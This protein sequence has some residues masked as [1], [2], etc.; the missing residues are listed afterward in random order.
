VR[1]RLVLAVCAPL[2]VGAAPAPGGWSVSASDDVGVRLESKTDDPN[3]L[4]FAFDFHGTAGYASARHDLPM[5]LPADYRIRFRLRGTGAANTLQLKFLDASGQNVWWWRRVDQPLPT[6]WTEVS[7]EP[8]QVEFAWGPTKDRRLGAIASVEATVA[9]EQGGA[10]AVEIRDLRIEP[11]AP[12][13]AQAPALATA[14]APDRTAMVEAAAKAAPRGRYPR[15]FVGEQP[16]WTLIGVEGGADS[17]LMSE[18]G[19]L[20]VGRGGFSIEPFVVQDG[21]LVSWADVA[22]RQSLQ[23]G[24]LPMP[25]VRWRAK[26][27]TLDVRGFVAGDARSARLYGRY[28]IANTTSRPLRL[29]LVLAVRP[30][31]VNGPRQFLTTPGGASKIGRA[32]WDGSVL[33]VDQRGVRPLARPDAVGVASFDDGGLDAALAQ[34]RRR[35]ITA[36]DAK[37][38]ATAALVYDLRLAPRQRRVIGVETPLIGAPSTAAPA[39]LERERQLTAAHWRAALGRVEISAGGEG[40]EVTAAIRTSLAH[41]LISREGPALRPG[42]RSYARSWIRDGSMMAE[43]LLRLD[44]AD[45]ARDYLD[46]YGPHQ[47]SSGKI[48]CCVDHRGADPTPE[49]DSQGEYLFLAGEVWR[50]T[51]DR[52]TAEA[53]WPYVLAAARD[54]DR[55]RLSER[56]EANRTPER[57]A[58]WGLMPPSISHEGYSD[59]PAYSYWDDLWAL[60]G[61]RAGVDLAQ[62]L[63][64]PELAELTA[65]RDQFSADLKA[66]VEAAG[67]RW[68]I[69]YMPGAADRGDFDATSTT[70]ALAPGDPGRGLSQPRL[71]AT[72]ERYWRFVQ[73]RDS[74]KLAWTDYTPYEW[75]NVGALLRLGWPDRALAL[76]HRMM[77]DRRPLAWNQWAEVVG[78]LPREPRFIGDMPHAWVASDFIRSA[79]DLF[80]YDRPADHAL[81]LAAGVPLSWTKGPGVRVRNLQT[82]YGPLSYSLKSDG[83]GQILILDAGASPPGGFVLRSASGA[84]RVIRGPG[85]YR[86][87]G[88]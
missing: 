27:W 12:G 56:T 11:V 44:R 87:T 50:Y 54:M 47:F 1:I 52:E 39:D 30:L 46:W 55:L 81:V 70:I 66:S 43:A 41:I 24:D 86:L 35:S 19:A 67:A 33:S 5:Q 65:S 85:R 63:G 83:R 28:E 36:T 79:L 61:Y 20:E 38:L 8:R 7:L 62:A 25:T 48:P 75:R 57:R 80:A 14:V 40:A 32:A 42:T 84:E 4:R 88:G 10:G 49:N 53:A 76:T 2:L 22:S 17:A 9:A 68:G 60:E 58:Y 29:R 72:F 16:Y 77:L 51:H 34:A 59:V 21:K 82:P 74:G 15:G 3:G 23:D 64:K 13:T 6:D 31:Q 71:R 37:G 73:D 78:R 26:G 69:D 45:V 18:D